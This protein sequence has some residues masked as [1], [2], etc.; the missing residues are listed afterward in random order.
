MPYQLYGLFLFAL[1]GSITPGPNNILL[2]VSGQHFG[3]RKSLPLMIG[4]QTGFFVLLVLSALGVSALITARP[5]LHV[6]MKAVA[7]A[8]LLYLA[9]RI[10]R[11]DR[12]QGDVAPRLITFSQAFFMQFINPKAWTL[13]LNGAAAFMPV[14]A[15]PIARISA[16]IVVFISVGIFSMTVW[17]NAGHA[18]SRLVASPATHRLLTT[19][20]ALLLAST[21]IAVWM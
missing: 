8:W 19:I 18:L 11:M 5:G 7:S 3:V 16:F 1:I 2:F 17:V 15:T 4:I 9:F 14:Y 10:W 12:L 20:L 6:V 13:T 21:L